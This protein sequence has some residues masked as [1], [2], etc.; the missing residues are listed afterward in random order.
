MFEVS[1]FV[2]SIVSLW[3]VF[4]VTKVTPYKNLEVSGLRFFFFSFCRCNKNPPWTL[5]L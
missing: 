5:S 3:V 4:G 2:L 1:V